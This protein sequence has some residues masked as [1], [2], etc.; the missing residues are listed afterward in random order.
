MLCITKWS[1]N[2]RTG[3]EWYL[4]QG[5]Q[6]GKKGREGHK[7]AVQN[8]TNKNPLFSSERTWTQSNEHVTYFLVKITK[9]C[10]AGRRPIPGRCMARNPRVARPISEKS[11][12]QMD[13]FISCPHIILSF[14]EPCAIGGGLDPLWPFFIIYF[15]VLVRF[16]YFFLFVCFFCPIAFYFWGNGVMIVLDHGYSYCIIRLQ[17]HRLDRPII[18]AQGWS[19]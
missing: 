6:G 10:Q 17:C 3:P 8:E 7:N 2:Y 11:E 12:M 13:Y 18:D 14:D 19:G 4:P 1:V 15:F 16:F 9:N 5:G